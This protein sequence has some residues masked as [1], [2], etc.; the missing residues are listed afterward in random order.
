VSFPLADSAI[1]IHAARLM[2]LDCARR[3]DSDR[4]ARLQLAM[5]KTFATE[6][7]LRT[8]DRAMQVHGAMGFTN[9]LGISEA[10]QQSRRICV[11]DGSAE[12]LRRQIVQQ[13][14]KDFVPR[15]G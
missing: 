5:A 11:A 15:A 12:I 3:L 13:L 7:S 9:E 14:R 8:L 4:P 6:M 10:W 1:D 2:G